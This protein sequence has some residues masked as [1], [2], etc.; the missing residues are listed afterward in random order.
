M[1]IIYY[2]ECTHISI[3]LFHNLVM[4]TNL[5]M[6]TTII[7]Q[8]YSTFCQL[9]SL[10]YL[11]EAVMQLL[12]DIIPSLE[13]LSATA[14]NTISMSVTYG[15]SIFTQFISN[16]INKKSVLDTCVDMTIGCLSATLMI[17]LKTILLTLGLARPEIALIMFAAILFL[18]LMRRLINFIIKEIKKN[19]GEQK[20]TY[21]PIYFSNIRKPIYFS[22]IRKP[23]YFSNIRKPIYFS[24]IR[25]PIYLSKIEKLNDKKKKIREEKY[26]P[27]YMK[28]IIPLFGNKRQKKNLN[29]YLYNR[30]NNFPY[31]SSCNN[32]FISCYS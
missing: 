32:L 3:L 31:L 27:K 25:K 7:K 1:W 30:T 16:L 11:S 13:Q 9:Y 5:G 19:N 10:T 26:R 12:N 29:E 8:L 4:F 20:F 18:A 17:K 2:N 21:R 14:L 6:E 15:I 23:I 24:N 28:N 22:N